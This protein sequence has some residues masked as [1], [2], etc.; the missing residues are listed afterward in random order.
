M[1]R[2]DLLLVAVTLAGAYLVKRHHSAAPVDELG[3]ILGPTAAL[4]ELVTGTPFEREGGTGYL[5]R[6]AHFIIARPCAGVNFWI[7]A[8]C[9][10]V[11]AFIG[12]RRTAVGK[13]LLVAGSVVGAFAATLVA[14]T[15]RIALA[16]WLHTDVGA[17]GPLDRGRVH[18]LAGVVVYTVSLCVLFLTARRALSPRAV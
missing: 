9:A 1:R 3:Y 7:V 4:V 2:L 12:T 8:A 6:D 14:N 18:H 10:A 16:L 11:V 5:A 15:A 17:V 13:V